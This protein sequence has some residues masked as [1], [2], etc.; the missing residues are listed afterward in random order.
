MKTRKMKMNNYRSFVIM[1][2]VFGSIV[3]AAPSQFVSDSD[4]VAL[5]HLDGNGND[6]SSNGHHLTVDE[7]DI[8][9]VSGK[10][11]QAVKIG[12]NTWGTESLAANHSGSVYPGSGDWTVDAWINAEELQD[13]RMDIAWHYSE[14]WAGHDPFGFYYDKS[15]NTLSGMVRDASPQAT[16]VEESLSGLYDGNGWIHVAMQYNY[17]ESIQLF[18]GSDSLLDEDDFLGEME[19]SLIME[20]LPSHN[21]TIGG[22]AMDNKIGGMIDEVR[23]S[24]TARYVPEPASLLLLGLGGL[25]MRKKRKA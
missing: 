6:S 25:A 17:M 19:T 18:A 1:V 9:W 8:S 3:Y 21:I 15:T 4:T 20:Y 11:G 2:L 13:D 7:G 22:T 12:A 10:F 23:L 24:T 5:W 14:H 16:L